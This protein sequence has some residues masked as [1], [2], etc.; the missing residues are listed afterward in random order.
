M[1]RIIIG[2]DICPVG[3]IEEAFKKGSSELIF[4]DLLPLIK[5]ADFSLI[6]L[7]CPLIREPSPI[8]KDGLVLSASDKCVNGFK[9]SNIQ[10]VN[11]ANNYI[12]DHGE[13]G[14]SVTLEA[15]KKSDRYWF[16]AGENLKEASKP[17]IKTIK[18]SSFGFFG[19]A[20]Y[21]F[22]I[23]GKNSWGA[24]P[25]DIID[26]TQSIREYRKKLDHIIILLHGGKEYYHYP[27]PK[28]QKM[29]RFLI[30]EGVDAIIC[31]HSHCPG[32][33]EIFDGKPI[34]YG[35]GNLIFER[36]RRN[37]ESQFNGFLVQ[38]E[39]QDSEIIV[40]FIPYRQSNG[41][42]GAKRLDK[43]EEEEFLFQLE[44]RSRNVLSDDFIEESWMN[45]CRKEKYLYA[46]RLLGHNRLLR[47]INSKIHFTDWAYSKKSKMISRNVVECEIHREGLETLWR[48]G[49]Y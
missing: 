7:E 3:A 34:I 49:L 44:S 24:N 11:L 46:S 29:C 31:Q 36:I 38:L 26:I 15:L 28:L 32:S 12:L 23:A 17:L 47:F 27:S 2:G 42:L 30:K 4:N 10:A 1:T 9:N 18:E 39:F 5:S 22:S 40:K 25:L 35:Q 8:D 43:K 19:M 41:I 21:E 14:L 45:L 48:N 33:Y 37:N 13:Q 6:N 16:G 20:D